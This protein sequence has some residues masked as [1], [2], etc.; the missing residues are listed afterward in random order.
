M[1]SVSIGFFILGAVI[2]WGGFMVTLAITIKN[3]RKAN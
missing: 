1:T 3:E 2:L